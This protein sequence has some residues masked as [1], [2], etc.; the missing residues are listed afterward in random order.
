MKKITVFL[1]DDS[2]EDTEMTMRTLNNSK[3]ISEV[4]PFRKAE[5]A[6]QAI[7]IADLSKDADI[8][9]VFLDMNMPGMS[10][11]DFIRKIKSE[12][13]ICEIPIAILTGTTDLP[14]I[15]ESI[16]LGVKY[17]IQKPIEQEDIEKIAHEF[18]FN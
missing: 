11:L 6:L 14:E 4:F 2:M 17:F 15:K 8:P 5:T 16:R 3:Y 10:G 7:E 18:G 9:F 12:K 13:G 1:I